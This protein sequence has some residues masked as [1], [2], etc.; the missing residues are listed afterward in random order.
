[1]C[2]F[3]HKISPLHYRQKQLMYIFLHPSSCH[4][5]CFTESGVSVAT[6][7]TVTYLYQSRARQTLLHFTTRPSEDPT[8]V[9]LGKWNIGNVSPSGEDRCMKGI[10][11]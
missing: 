7:S 5:L 9:C 11:S 8:H 2:L 10:Y 1:M 4:S 3:I 6:V